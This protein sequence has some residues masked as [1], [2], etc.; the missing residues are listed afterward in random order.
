MP[1]PRSVALALALAP[2]A[3]SACARYVGDGRIDPSP[4]LAEVASFWHPEQ[5]TGVALAPGG[6]LF[7]NAPLWHDGHKWHVA[8]VLPGGEAVPYPNNAWNSFMEGDAGDLS[9]RFVCVQSV[10]VDALG[11]LWAIDAGA[12]RLKGPLPGA[13]KLVELDLANN[14]VRRVIPF[15]ATIA[16]EG[17]YL[18]DVRVDTESDTA[19]ITDSGLGAIV[20]VDLA[21]NTARRLLADHPST[22]A[23]EGVVPVV[24]GRPLQF[25]DGKPAVIHSDGLALDHAG[26]WLYWQA[27]TARTLYRLSVGALVDATVPPESLETLVENLGRS[28]VT[29]GME[30]DAQGRLYF[31][32]LEHDAVVVR[33]PDGSYRT[34]AAQPS[35]AWPD[36][37]A[38]GRDGW[39]FFT[40]SQIHLSEWFSPQTAPPTTPYRV[41]KTRVQR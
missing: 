27:L 3:L 15:D 29:D 5:I 8:E 10:H 40:T 22:K 12:P 38:W 35:I 7:V 14:R 34:A 30:C 28:P 18:N 1:L 20:V 4:S 19:F 23:E 13:A 37:F 31:S 36:S 41:W 21:T 33:M 9:A 32:A 2:L 16:P 26:G 24:G 17:S 11:R 6:R 39:L 25:P